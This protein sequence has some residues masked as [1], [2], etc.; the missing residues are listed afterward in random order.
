MVRNLW[1]AAV[2]YATASA[3]TF[4]LGQVMPPPFPSELVPSPAGAKVAWILN[5]RGARN[6]WMAATPDYK[7]VRLTAYTGDSGQDIGQLRWTPDGRSLVYTRGGDLEF[8]GRPDP[9]P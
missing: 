3:P 9:N 4:T 5:E 1:L 7:G 2:A 6:V 8:L